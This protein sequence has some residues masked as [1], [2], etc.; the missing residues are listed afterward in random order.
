M[1][2]GRSNNVSLAVIG[3]GPSGSS[4]AIRFIQGAEKSSLPVRVILI[5]GK[6]FDVHYNQ[7]AG[8]LSPPI[9]DIL[10]NDLKVTLPYSIFKRQIRGYRLHAG[11]R[12]VLLVGEHRFGPTYAVRRVNFDRFMLQTAVDAGARLVRSRVTGL[13]FVNGEKGKKAVIYTEEGTFVTDYVIGAFG[14]DDGM[15]DIFEKATGMYR[16]AGKFMTTYVTK[17]PTE[18]K[19]IEKNLGDIIYAF[20]YP[21]AASRIEFGAITPKGDH[22]IANIAGEGISIDDFLRFLTQEDVKK[23][24][25]GLEPDPSR[26]YKGKFPSSPA[27]GVTGSNYIVVGD[28]TGFLR[29]FKG[30]GIT[31]AV[32][33]GIYAAD[34]ILRDQLAGAG[35]NGYTGK[36]KELMKDY[37]YGSAVKMLTRVAQKSGTL[38]TIIEASKLNR[39][40]YEGLF[41]SVS[42]NDSFKNIFKGNFNVSSVME[43]VKLKIR[44]G[45]G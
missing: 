29:P 26:V 25:P 34:S 43:I 33:T 32:Q 12:E 9:E 3:G 21:S 42:G 18:R 39:P 19:V 45:W 10:L 17:V 30:K 27:K 23:Y 6:D 40:L 15:I 2:N 37:I 11:G 22:I 14:L 7:C 4:A 1:E 24:I 28:A 38:G 13:E 36:C 16:R 20:L 35:L 44:E 41:N 31:M 5:E 8:V